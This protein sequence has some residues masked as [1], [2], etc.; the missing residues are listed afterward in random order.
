MSSRKASRADA[1]FESGLRQLQQ[2]QLEQARQS[3]RRAL[4]LAPRHPDALHLLGAI[5]LQE[6]DPSGAIELLRQAVAMRP[7]HPTY[8]ANLAYAYFGLK[9]LPEALAAFERATRLDPHD[10]ELQLGIGSCL[11]MMGK[12]AEAEAALRRLV[13]RHPQFALGWFNLAKA[14]DD[15][16]RFDEACALYR[17]ATELAPQLAD[18]HINLGI[19]LNRLDRFEEAEPALRAGIALNPGFAPAYVNL[20]VVL[21]SLRRHEEAEALCRE[22]IRR[23]PHRPAARAML[24]KSLSGQGRW[25]EAL[26]WIEEVVDEAPDNRN[27]L[28]DFGDALARHGRISE[29]LEAFDRAALHGEDDSVT[30]PVPFA[31]AFALFS[32]GR[33]REGAAAYFI[34]RDKR[35]ASAT[36]HLD[37]PLAATL[38]SD[39]RGQEVCL[40]GEQGIGDEIFF[41]R[42]APQLK[43]RG[44]RVIYQGSGKIASILARCAALEQVLSGID[45]LAAANLTL[46]VGDLPHLLDEVPGTTPLRARSVLP[47]ARPAGAACAPGAYWRARLF[48]PELPPPL[49]LQPLAERMASVSERLR[50]LGPAPYIGLTWRAGTD[51]KGQRGK[52]SQLFKEAP[53]EFLA[54]ALQEE[55]RGTLLSLQR[56]PRE[57]ETGR[58]AALLGRPLHDLSADNE[59]LEEMLALLAVLDEYMGVSNTNMHLRAG[60]GRTARVLVPWP[61][62]WRWM[63][64]GDESPWFPGFRIYRQRPDGDWSEA[65]GRLTRDLQT[66]FGKR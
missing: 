66:E 39:L 3:C 11:G 57:G 52:V 27:F 15:Q 20:A 5:A 60:T 7:D 56:N 12:A 58:F 6:G 8:Q 21:N 13:E 59:D 18:A 10:P 19:A 26:R 50:R 28:C 17:R 48:C 33:I 35:I 34:N 45:T 54:T 14:L 32:A 64:S 22:A 38:P 53:F 62:E 55:S 24:A 44:C 29:A 42:Y 46:L 51:I 41:L 40:V 1:L 9:R 43:A 37:R 49:T 30:R 36:N 23:D 63:I 61:A 31:R 2:G 4:E 65:L 16:K 25:K 47:G